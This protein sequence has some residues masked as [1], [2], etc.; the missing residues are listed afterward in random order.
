MF[1]LLTNIEIVRNTIDRADNMS[2]DLLIDVS[3]IAAGKIPP[4]LLPPDLLVEGLQA[5]SKVLPN[6]NTLLSPTSSGVLWNYYN[7]TIVNSIVLQDGLRLLIDLRIIVPGSQRSPLQ[8]YPFSH[9]NPRHQLLYNNR[10]NVPLFGP[11]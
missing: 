4:H 5:V 10:I 1:S 11:F 3:A 7:L 6:G 8:H 9:T 2:Q